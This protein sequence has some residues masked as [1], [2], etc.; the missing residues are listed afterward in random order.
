MKKLTFA[1]FVLIVHLFCST[2]TYPQLSDGPWPTFQH[3]ARHT[4]RSAYTGP[5]GGDLAWIYET[6]GWLSAPV[7]GPGGIVYVGSSDSTLYALKPD[8][9]LKWSFKA[10]GSVGT[11]SV[12]IDGTIFF[13]S[14]AGTVYAVNEDGIEKWS[15]STGYA[16]YNAAITIDANGVLYFGS[17]EEKVYALNSNG[18][19]KWKLDVVGSVREPVAIGEDGTIY[20]TTIYNE[21][22][23][24]INQDGTVKWKYDIPY[25]PGFIRY[26]T[27]P[28]LAEDSAIYFGTGWPDNNLYAVDQNGTLKWKYL[29]G[30]G[31]A[32]I[33]GPP[34]LGADG[35]VYFGS[36]DNSFYAINGNGTFKWSLETGGKITASAVIDS[37]GTLFFGSDDGKLYAVNSDG[38]IKWSYMSKDYSN[39][40][41]IALNTD[42]TMYISSGYTLKAFFN[43]G[44]GTPDLSISSDKITFNPMEQSVRGSMVT[45][46]AE[47][48][49]ESNAANAS[50]DVDF[51]YNDKTKPIGTVPRY[52][53]SGSSTNARI[54]W[55]TKDLGKGSYN[56]IVEIN[57]TKPLETN[58]SNNEAQLNYTL[59]PNLQDRIDN[60]V[61]GDTLWVEPG[62]YFEH[63]TLRN[64][65]VVKS[66]K[67]Y[68]STIID[69]SGTGVVVS[70]PYLD[71]SAV[72]DGFTIRNGSTG[73]NID[74]GG[75]TIIRNKI[76]GNVLGLYMIGSFVYSD[77]VIRK[78]VFIGNTGQAIETNNSWAEV[79]NNTIVNNG[80]GA[81]GYGYYSPSPTYNNC[82]IWGNGDDL[83]RTAYATY[84]CIGNGDTG[85]G[86]ISSDPLFVDPEKGDFHLQALSP[87]IDA[88]DTA[89]TKDPDGTRTD[90]GAFYFSKIATGID[91]PNDL[92]TPSAF[93]LSQN[94]PN[95]FNQETT[96]NYSL[97]RNSTVIIS[98]FD[99]K[100][101][102]IMKLVNE[103][104]N[105]GNYTI[106]FNGSD[107]SNGIYF[108]RLQAGSFSQTK[109]LLLMKQ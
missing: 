1:G 102:E 80:S 60:T 17:E 84:S 94:Y 79:S 87:C 83:T 96:I 73:I 105:P 72:I 28:V 81:D 70:A 52:I 4:G 59:S 35:T 75:V 34:A 90:M 86:N 98:I 13:C 30:S 103:E 8:G 71:P 55:D 33:S 50:F 42:R 65:V 14:E 101:I 26:I 6:N 11:A 37:E 39:F 58:T 56:I 51:Y 7:I 21:K 27:S 15:Y 29:I 43:L 61:M 100:G 93:S 95:P 106:R 108:Y 66:K 82:I 47:I 92:S 74:R 5:S 67:G 38:S 78:N 49:E 32:D 46:E 9:N 54:I 20:A 19:E 62:T 57:S 89:S 16:M 23:Y 22:L 48:H 45:I 91:S 104:K 36:Q 41:F 18:S 88:G 44:A 25:T 40:Q 85:T 99:T 12:G 31:F 64:G 63:I 53:L 69:G 10:N 76:S 68:D 97:P 3:D 109:K 107:L 2:N 24:A 77:P